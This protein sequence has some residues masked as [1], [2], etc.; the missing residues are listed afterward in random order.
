MN[1]WV[2]LLWGLFACAAGLLYSFLCNWADCSKGLHFFL[3]VF[4]FLYCFYLL[5]IVNVCFLIYLIKLFF[6][7]LLKK[8]KCHIK[9]VNQTENHI[10]KRPYPTLFTNVLHNRSLVE[11][12]HQLG[13]LSKMLLVK[14]KIVFFQVIHNSTRVDIWNSQ[15]YTKT[16]A[17][18]LRAALFLL[19]SML[20]FASVHR[21]EGCKQTRQ[22]T[23]KVMSG[24]D[25]W[26]LAFVLSSLSCFSLYV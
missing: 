7:P 23:N 2:W 17:R 20:Q 24:H 5:H 22:Q 3:F 1:Y 19:P 25:V 21:C 8:Y 15:M 4:S 16:H 6:L 9:I 10:R 13:P 11:D 12:S 26:G 14:D 18:S